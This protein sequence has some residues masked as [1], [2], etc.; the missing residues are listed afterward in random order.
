MLMVQVGLGLFALGGSAEAQAAARYMDL[1]EA[2]EVAE[3]IAVIHTTGTEPCEVEGDHWTYAQ[4]VS[5]EA[6][7]VIKGK[8]TAD[9]EILAEK[10]FPCASVHYDAPADYLV[11]LAHDREHWV[12]VN[13]GMGALQI[14][15]EG[16]VQWPYQNGPRVPLSDVLTQIRGMVGEGIVAELEM[17]EDEPSEPTLD[18]KP[19]V[20][21]EEE[22]IPCGLL[23]SYE[24]EQAESELRVPTWLS[25][26]F[27]MFGGAM[28]VLL[29]LGVGWRLRTR[30]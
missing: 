2:V 19:P 7:A 13:H 26:P 24:Q 9:L 12:T 21:T 5:A 23:A 6:R 27:A 20:V 11:F 17:L 29:G 28:A 15:Q 10:S 22:P 8:L 1:A 16:I 14:D 4:R 18:A 25:H 3:A 30:K